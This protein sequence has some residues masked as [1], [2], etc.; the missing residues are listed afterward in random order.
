MVMVIGMAKTH[1]DIIRHSHERSRE[2][3]IKKEL[4][5]SRKLL[6]PSDFRKVLK[7]NRPLLDVALPVMEEMYGFL[8]GSGFIII[9]TDRNGCILEVNGDEEPL[10][11]AG[12]LSLVRGAYMDEASI[13]TNA[14]GTAI[15]EDSPV[16]VTASEHFISAYHRWTCSAA[17]IHDVNGVIAGTLNLT[18]HSKLAHPH[19]LGLIVAAVSAI[20]YRINN[21]HIQKQLDNAN[22]FA[23]AMMNNLAYGLFAIDLNDEIMWV[24]DF[25]CRSV[26]IRRL[27]LINIPITSIFKE[28][29]EVKETILQHKNYLDEEGKFSIPKLKEKYVFSAYLINTKEGEIR[30]YLLAFREYSGILKM[31]NQ[32]AGHSTRYTFDDF[33][34][35]SD[36]AREMMRYCRTIARKP[37]TVLITGETGT[38]KEIIAQAIHHE[39]PR[40]EAAFV[41]INCGAIS[42]SLIESELFGYAEGAFTGA[43]KGGRPGKFEL[44][45]KGTL[46]LDEIG[47]MPLDMQV[48]LL[49][50]IQEKAV[51]RVGSEKPVPVDV[52]IIAAT[53]KDLEEEVK[54]GRFRMDLYYRINVMQVNVPALRERRDDIPLLVRYFLKRKSAKF[55]IPIPDIPPNVFESLM[56]YDWPGNV[57]E[58]ENIVE[59]AV[60]LGG[61]ISLQ[62]LP[63]ESPVPVDLTVRNDHPTNVSQ[64]WNL[65]EIE[66][67]TIVR[68][69][70]HFGDNI[71][72]IAEALGVSRNTLYLKMKKYRIR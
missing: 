31:V 35:E 38:G 43:R 67:D 26:N 64:S 44:A 65:E 24:N 20:E 47:E 34:G 10:E 53:N 27:H 19:T 13:G 2:Y 25:A 70:E 40:Q 41:A 21:V 30:G 49:R 57:R 45:D 46:F 68:A 50:A 11:D 1:K 62:D 4:S 39:S 54:A 29:N 56:R 52:R 58:L 63:K 60:L 8:R 59:K 16:Q 48:K 3:G 32:Y 5:V 61:N 7:E 42:E 9:L 37:T 15:S 55:D 22:Q 18:G 6:S 66:K 51:I 69:M 28:W 36:A 14:M 23:F 71:S 12:K 17:P 72:K 33:I